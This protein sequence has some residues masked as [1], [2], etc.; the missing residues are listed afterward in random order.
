MK[1]EQSEQKQTTNSLDFKTYVEEL[2]KRIAE[3]YPNCIS[4]ANKG[5]LEFR[6]I[7]E[8]ERLI[9]GSN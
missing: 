5:E 7:D 9:G 6:D 2:N 8:I 4:T 3:L 1:E